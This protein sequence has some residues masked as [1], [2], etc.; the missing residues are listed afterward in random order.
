MKSTEGFND[1]KE[2]AEA[3]KKVDEG[4]KQGRGTEAEKKQTEDE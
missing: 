1:E 4:D 3:D 2:G